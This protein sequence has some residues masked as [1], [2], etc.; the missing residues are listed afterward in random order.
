[1]SLAPYL[2]DMLTDIHRNAE[3]FYFS[4]LESA[5]AEAKALDNYHE[6][7]VGIW[8]AKSNPDADIEVLANVEGRGELIC[9]VFWG[10]VWVNEDRVDKWGPSVLKASGQ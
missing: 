10:A 9:I 3:C 2:V 6:Q 1:M 5:L 4:S 7:P 8:N